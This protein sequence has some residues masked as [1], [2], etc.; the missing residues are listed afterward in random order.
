[1]MHIALSAALFEIEQ[2]RA[3]R[4]AAQ[5]EAARAVEAL[6]R[7]HEGAARQLAQPR[8][9]DND[10]YALTAIATD[11]EAVLATQGSALYWLTQQRREAAVEALEKL[12]TDLRQDPWGTTLHDIDS[13]RN[14]LR[15]RAAALR[16]GEVPNE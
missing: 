5:A 14:I 6:R 16:A 12:V 8:D 9:N 7:C 13:L 3:E 15:T 11:C 4:D 2:L 1:M 10:Q